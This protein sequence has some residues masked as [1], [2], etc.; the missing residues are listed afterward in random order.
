MK[1]LNVFFFALVIVLACVNCE[2]GE[3][4]PSTVGGE[5]GQELDFSL[6]YEFLVPGETSKVALY[7][8]FP[9]TISGR[10]DVHE[11]EFS[12]EPSRIF[13]NKGNDYAE[14]IF[15]NPEKQFKVE[16]RIKAELFRYDL[17]FA[18]M[19]SHGDF[20]EEPNLSEY[21]REER[22]IEKD[23][24]LIQVVAGSIPGETSIDTIHNIYDYVIDNTEPDVSRLKGAGA[25]EAALTKRGMC[26]DYCDLFVALC[27]A[28]NIPARVVMGYKTEFRVSPKHSWVEAYVEGLGWVPFD[29]TFGENTTLSARWKR[30]RHL[31]PI[32]IY[33]SGI[34]NDGVL[35]NCHIYVYGYNGERIQSDIVKY[36]GNLITE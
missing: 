31:K 17:A 25:L 8:N 24:P 2:D 9:H 5:E 3:T 27:R 12:P 15:N 1:Y 4:K 16:V 33:F 29:P 7:V 18:E 19:K 13:S 11:V 35:H 14:F 26:I 22:M 28:K 6:C 20:P 10:Q 30:F 23:H 21:L 34:R 36:L 32:Y